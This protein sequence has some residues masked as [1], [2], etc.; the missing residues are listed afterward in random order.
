MIG[1]KFKKS[2]LTVLQIM[3]E[4]RGKT[5][6][7]SIPVAF[8]FC[9]P[10]VS[11][12]ESRKELKALVTWQQMRFLLELAFIVLAKFKNHKDD[13]LVSQPWKLRLFV[14]PDK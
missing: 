7:F 13:K 5:G 2:Y 14:A 4:V 8:Q 1:L 10:G 3:L 9:S 12:S 6:G 11:L